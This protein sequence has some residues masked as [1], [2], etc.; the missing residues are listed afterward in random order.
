LGHLFK[1]I[2]DKVLIELFRL[3]KDKFVIELLN[4]AYGTDIESFSYMPGILDASTKLSLLLLLSSKSI[5]I[6][7]MGDGFRFGLALL[8]L[9]LA[10]NMKTVLIEELENHQHPKALRYLAKALTSYAI[11]NNAQLFLTTHSMELVKAFIR[12]AEDNLNNLGVFHFELIGGIL[13]ARALE[14][15]DAK[16][17]DDLGFDIRVL[18]EYGKK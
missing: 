18:D 17:L 2:E 10:L 12:A 5:R 13:E 8:T 3:R 1:D 15:M 14:G 11:K 4:E 9:I 7:E 6:D 16:V